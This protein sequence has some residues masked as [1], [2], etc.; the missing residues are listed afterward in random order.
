MRNVWDF[1][2]P[3]GRCVGRYWLPRLA[4]TAEATHHEQLLVDSPTPKRGPIPEPGRSRRTSDRGDRSATPQ[5][6]GARA[7]LMPGSLGKIRLQLR[8]PECLHREAV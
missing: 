6:L 7:H 1:A 8:R 4:R 5:R 3:Y 2:G